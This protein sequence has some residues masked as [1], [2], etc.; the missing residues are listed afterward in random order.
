MIV[1][2]S[3]PVL[4]PSGPVFEHRLREGLS[5]RTLSVPFPNP[6]R[7]LDCRSPLKYVRTMSKQ[8]SYILFLL[9]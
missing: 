1:E 9:P 6:L 4:F 5:L 3:G 2:S 8:A 7:S